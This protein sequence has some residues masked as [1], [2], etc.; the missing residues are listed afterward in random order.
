MQGSG[1]HLVQECRGG[2]ARGRGIERGGLRGQL[3]QG[4][5]GASALGSGRSLLT[6]QQE[7]VS[8]KLRRLAD[9]NSTNLYLTNLPYYFENHDV[10]QLLAPATVLSVR[11][12]R[13]NDALPSDQRGDGGA[14]KG[15]G[16]ARWVSP[17]SASF[18]VPILTLAADP[19]LEDRDIADSVISRL[20]GLH[21][22]GS[23]LPLRIRY[24]QYW[25]LSDP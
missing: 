6:S 19:S 9:E 17:P 2:R 23:G 13:E 12:L 18:R 4:W 3:R 5:L 8:L 25:N 10:V 11:I 1:L 21:L 20:N 22:P 15:I 24:G 16:F 7:S 14:S